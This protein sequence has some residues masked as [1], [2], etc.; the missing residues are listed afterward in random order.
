[1]IS[2]LHPHFILSR[3][4]ISL[5]ILSVFFLSSLTFG[6][7]QKGWAKK[8]KYLVAIDPGHGGLNLGSLDPRVPGNF[9]KTYTLIIA[10][11]VRDF[12]L[13]AGVYVWMSRTKDIPLSLQNRMKR[14]SATGA[15]LFVSVHINDFPIV[16]PRGHGTFFL[17]PE[18]FI[19]SQER[20][21]SFNQQ[22]EGKV[23]KKAVSKVPKSPQL[24]SMLL[25][26]LHQGAQHESV[27]LAHLV[28]QALSEV[29]PFG[30]RGVK[31]ADFGV[32]KGI[33]LPAIVCEVGF[34]NHPREGP[35]VTSKKGMKA[36][37]KAIATGIIRYLNS[38]LGAELRLDLLK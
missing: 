18:V 22:T 8:K 33:A 36:L 25:D 31:Q 19:E 5:L 12:L 14:A 13:K 21:H 30:T 27:H 29:S 23:L 1:M 26:L 28:N 24:Q 3:I 16:G 2:F 10:K 7:L 11:H 38:R 4:Q 9:E 17:A 37:A 15:D 20:I 35:Y 32:I 34:I 6:D